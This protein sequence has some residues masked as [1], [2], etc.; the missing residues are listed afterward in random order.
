MSESNGVGATSWVT[1]PSGVTIKAGSWCFSSAPEPAKYTQIEKLTTE[2]KD[3][4]DKLIDVENRYLAA[5]GFEMVLDHK[6]GKILWKITGGTRSTSLKDKR[7]PR[8]RA[9][10]VAR[11]LEIRAKVAAVEQIAKLKAEHGIEEGV[12]K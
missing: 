3:A 1:V 12:T 6:D 8:E 4:K 11:N 2:I 9:L 7:L 10:E 5:Q